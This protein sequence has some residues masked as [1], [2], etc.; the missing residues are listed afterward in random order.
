MLQDASLINYIA[1]I[2]GNVTRKR[3]GYVR[4]CQLKKMK[5][6]CV[7]CLKKYSRIKKLFFIR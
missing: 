6:G 1:F 5:S 2:S 7:Q 4:E 3:E